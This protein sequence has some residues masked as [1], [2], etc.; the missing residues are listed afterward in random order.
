M[1]EGRT[2]NKLRILQAK[3]IRRT[4]KNCSFSKMVSLVL[5]KGIKKLKKN[6]K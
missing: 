4:K 3:R 6:K 2:Y 5:I 1:I